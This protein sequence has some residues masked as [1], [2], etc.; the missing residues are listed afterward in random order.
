LASLSRQAVLLVDA[1]FRAPIL[2]QRLKTQCG[3]GLAE[4]IAGRG[5]IQEL[6]QPS[7][8]GSF[9]FLQAGTSRSLGNGE[10]AAPAW[11]DVLRNLHGFQRVIFH[12]GPLTQNPAA[13]VITAE[14]D[15]VVLALAAGIRRRGEAEELQRQ[16]EML[17]TRLIGAVLT[18]RQ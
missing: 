14:S 17:R 10:L 4:L 15:V 18:H 9:F 8:E 6:I 7:A 3:P 2:H 16:V 13:M 1:D 11:I 5:R 12:V